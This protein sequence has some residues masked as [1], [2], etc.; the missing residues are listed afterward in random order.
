MAALPWRMAGS[1]SGRMQLLR[2]AEM[3]LLFSIVGVSVQAQQVPIRSLTFEGNQRIDSR[4]LRGQ[5]HISRD[6][7]TYNPDTLKEELLNLEKYCQNEGFLRARVGPPAVDLRP[8]P[9][10]IHVASIR[11]PIFEG[12][13]FSVGKITVE[14]AKVFSPETLMQMCPLRP[15]Q[16]YSRKRIAEWQ[17]KIEDGYH[18]LGYLRFEAAVREEIHDAQ[19]TVDCVIQC[20]EG[21]AYSV[22]KITIVGDESIDRSD[23]KRH[24]LLGEGGLYNP[25]MISLSIQ[26]LNQMNIYQPIADSD[27]E[28]KIDDASSTVDLVF[29]LMLRR[30][31]GSGPK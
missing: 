24:L 26:F 12:P 5:M 6:G 29:H 18:T 11:V 17:D 3:V 21:N 15:G 30:K 19:N 8:D 16:A 28:V 4:R 7:G 31:P 25:E 2:T 20:K 10:N 1:L 13:L 27:V 22:G 14:N 23:F 9:A